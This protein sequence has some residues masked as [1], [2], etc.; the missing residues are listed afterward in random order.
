MLPAISAC[1]GSSEFMRSSL[2]LTQI[3]QHVTEAMDLRHGV[4]VNEGDANR[5]AVLIQPEA[6]HQPRAIEVTVANADS[7]AGHRFRHGRRCV[8]REGEAQRRNA[9]RDSSRGSD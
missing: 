2:A 9:C 1:E 5:A 3:R 8:T 7:G 4:V 6:L